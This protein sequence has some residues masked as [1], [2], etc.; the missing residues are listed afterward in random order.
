[1]LTN[2]ENHTTDLTEEELYYLPYIK[3]YLVA[4][5][6]DRVVKQNDLCEQVNMK[7]AFEHGRDA[8]N[9]SA[10]KMRKY[11]NY[12]RVNGDLA[13]IAT[14]EGCYIS[15]DPNDIMKQIKSLEERARQIQRAADGM[16]ALLNI[17]YKQDTHHDKNQSETRSERI[18]C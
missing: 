18:T 16:K 4:L 1:M 6:T 15:N 9:I 13:L 14:S 3:R 17:N 12:F 2:F 11:F 5:L 8:I 7:L 10:A